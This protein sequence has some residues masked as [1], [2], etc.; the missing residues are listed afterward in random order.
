MKPAERKARTKRELIIEVWK[1]LDCPRVGDKELVEIQHALREEFGEGAVDSPAAI[2]RALADNSAELRHPEVLECDARWRETEIHKAEADELASI[3]PPSQ[4]LTLKH[5]ARAVKKMERLRKKLERKS[6]AARLRR[7]RN[8][9]LR[10]KQRAQLLARDPVLDQAERAKQ[11]EIAEW[12]RV[13]LERPD[14]FDDWLELR[15]RSP[16]FRNRFSTEKEA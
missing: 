7:L 5:A 3:F 13:W 9:V 11:E 2:A 6:D 16:D 14:I 4:R 10:Q 15:R 12:L 8:F 1:Q